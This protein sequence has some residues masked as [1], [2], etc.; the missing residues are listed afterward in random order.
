MP[1]RIVVAGAGY[2]G[3]CAAGHLARRLHP[4]DVEV[5]VVDP[6]P[7]FVER[8]RLHQLAAAARR[9]PLAGLFAGTGVRLRA[10]RV[11]A[12]DPERRTV[13]VADAAPRD[14]AGAIDRLDHDTLLHAL[15]STVAD[16]GVPGV[17]E[18]AF[19]VAGR[20]APPD[21]PRRVVTG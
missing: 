5:T 13:T 17:A 10:A 15:A 8:I 21:A 20:P 14:A 11:T 6:G 3:A 4:A 16:R 18:H 12:V 1:H 2:A 19:H 9:I 7:D